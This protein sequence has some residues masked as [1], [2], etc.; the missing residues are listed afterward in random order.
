M[1]N[2]REIALALCNVIVQS[3]TNMIKFI[4]LSRIIL[5][6]KIKTNRRI[7]KL[8]LSRQNHIRIQNPISIIIRDYV[9]SD[10]HSHFRM[11]RQ[12]FFKLIQICSKGNLKKKLFW[13]EST[14][15][16]RKKK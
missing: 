4:Q 16:H 6:N 11:T 10:F 12:T 5:K 9:E 15:I 2:D 3:K 1:D 14:F 8:V 13:W 7:L